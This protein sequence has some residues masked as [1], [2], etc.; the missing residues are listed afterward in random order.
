M[1]IFGRRLKQ[2]KRIEKDIKRVVKADEKCLKNIER[3][4]RLFREMSLFNEADVKGI[5]DVLL[6][7]AEQLQSAAARKRYNTEINIKLCQAMETVYDRSGDIDAVRMMRI[8]GIIAQ[9]S[10]RME[11]RGVDGILTIDRED[12]LDMN[13]SFVADGLQAEAFMTP[14]FPPGTKQSPT[15]SDTEYTHA[16]AAGHNVRKQ[17]QHG[18]YVKT[19]FN[20]VDD[21]LVNDFQE[22]KKP[23]KGNFRLIKSLAKDIKN[24][25][26]L[27]AV[28]NKMNIFRGHVNANKAVHGKYATAWNK[29]IDKTLDVINKRIAKFEVKQA[30]HLQKQYVA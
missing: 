2:E 1:A 27:H 5:T 13:R 3:E 17:T 15:K 30:K 6:K 25:D 21:Y 18:P 29:L 24:L 4:I 16:G 20:E 23:Y 10:Q 19:I 9:F 28:Q 14:D 26:D 7:L 8:E 11:D 12:S 22:N